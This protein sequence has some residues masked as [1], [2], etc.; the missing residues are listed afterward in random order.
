MRTK[1]NRHSTA[2]FTLIEIMI[3]ILVLGFV[4]VSFAG[5]FLLFERGSAATTD[6]AEAQQNTRVAL[7]FITDYLRQAGS[8]TDYFRGQSSIVYAEPYQI[9]FNAD[10]D[11]GRT[12]DGFPPLV[13]IDL[14]GSPNKVTPS[15]A[16]LYMPAENYDSD[17]ETLVF[18][19]DSNTDG[20]IT[21]ADRGDDPEEDGPNRNLFVLKMYIYGK[22]ESTASNEVRQFNLSMIR[23]PNLAPTWIIPQPLF[24]YYMDHDDNPATADRLFGDSN[25]SGELESGEIVALTAVPQSQLSRIRRVKVTAVGESDRYDKKH[26]TNGGFLNI[27]MNSEIYVRNLALTSSMIRGKVYHDADGD[28]A[29]DA[30]ETGIPNVEI[31]LAGHNRTIL[32]DNYGRY[33]FPLPAGDYSIQEIDPFGYTSTTA[34]IVSVTLAAGQT[35][36]VDFGDLSTLP[37]GVIRGTVFEDMDKD[38]I[39]AAGEKPLAGVQISMD[40]GVE[41]LTDDSGHYSFIAQQGVYTV[42]ETDPVGYSS[43]TPNSGTATIVSAD[44]TVTIDFGDYPGEVYGTLEGHVFLDENSDGARNTGE[45]GLPNVKI[46]LSSGDSTTTNSDGYYIF[47]IDPGIYS[48]T[49]NDPAGYTSTTV[50]TYVDIKIVADTTVVRDFG[51]ILEESWNFVEI[52][53]SNTERVLSVRTADLEE[54]TNGDKDI[55]LGTALGAGIGNMLIF[56][57]MWENMTTPISGLFTSDPTYRR[58]AGHN[59]NALEKIDLTHDGTPDVLSGLDNSIERNVQVWFTGSGGILSTSPDYSY[60]ASGLNE[61]MDFALADLDLDGNIDLVAGLKSPVGATGAFETFRGN[62]SGEFSS[63]SYVTVAGDSVEYVLG[64]IWAVDTGDIDG[65]GDQDIVVG[66]HYAIDVGRIDIYINEG[67]GSG[68]FSWHSRYFANGGVNDLLVLDMQEDDA[69]DA[70]ILVGVSTN[71]YVGELML[72]LN[73]NST[74][75]IPDTVGTS[76]FPPDV[77]PRYPDDGVIGIGEVLSITTLDMNND[78]FPDVA[79]GTRTS[80]LYTGQLIVYPAYGTLPSSGMVISHAGSGEIVTLDVADLNKDSYPDIVVGTRISSVQGSLIAYFGRDD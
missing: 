74:F 19:L 29:M 50:N 72:F 8:Q 24:Q 45:E 71:S 48:V 59:I 65:D 78:V 68:V 32:T 33:F 79:I 1:R 57:N 11:N 46:R 21:V 76:P 3:S 69:G 43:T 12:I 4:L 63:W 66:S 67:Y 20:A 41:T 9:V 22:N 40:S 15:G 35:K 2:G 16:T 38:G 61:V 25:G 51:D 14:A 54:D 31:R 64:G 49:E 37:I 17:A 18:T 60:L 26:E 58:D 6:Y 39:M 70:D 55:V 52:H 73:T 7:D 44:D 5:V 53:I 42:V 56:H 36:M 62:G 27:T 34:N 10:I 28:G 30:G 80:S 23:G 13:A 75:G 77:T 47:N